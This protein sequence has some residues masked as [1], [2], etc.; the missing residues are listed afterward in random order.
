MWS[1]FITGVV[2]IGVLFFLDRMIS[3]TRNKEAVVS[4]AE[5]VFNKFDCIVKVVQFFSWLLVMPL[6]FSLAVAQ[7]VVL[8]NEN[9]R[10][11]VAGL[12]FRQVLADITGFELSMLAMLSI[13]TALRNKY[14]AVVNM[15]DILKKIKF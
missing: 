8:S 10:N 9:F 15:K 7:V 1:C 5:S 6:M 2:Y 14:Y 13:C 4:N 12:S 11:F 3:Q